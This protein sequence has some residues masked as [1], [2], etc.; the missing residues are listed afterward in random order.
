MIELFRHP[1]SRTFLWLW[2]GQTISTFGTSVSAFALGVYLYE[3]TGQATPLAILGIAR[4]LPQIVL[5]PLAGVLVDRIDRKWAMLLSDVGQG[6]AILAVLTLFAAGQ[7]QPWLI[8][9]LFALASLADSLRWT[10]EAATITLLVPTEHLGRANGL[11]SLGEGLGGIGGPAAAGVLLALIGISHLLAIDVLTYALDVVILLS[12]HIPRA[13]ITEA[14][15]QA[16]SSFRRELTI[17]WRYIR[18]RSGLL[19]LLLVTAAANLVDI[20]VAWRLVP[21]LILA[22]TSGNTVTLGLVG[23]TFDLGMLAGGIAM[24]VWGGPRP[25][26]LGVLGGSI[27]VAL[28][29]EVLFGLGHSLPIWLLAAFLGPFFIPIRLGS[30]HT[31]WQSTVEPDL[32]GKVFA[33]RRAISQITFP[34]GLLIVGPLA[35]DVATPAMHGALGHALRPLF[36][37]GPGRSYAIVMVIFGLLAALVYALGALLPSVRDVET[38]LHDAVVVAG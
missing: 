20:S 29:G 2:L 38:R 9:L 7:L 21:P 33:V 28:A 3:T 16:K 11:Q 15:R 32:Q 35:D 19:Q 30:S 5:S 36:G 13:Q 22:E 25:R 24:T 18:A 37:A 26:I 6:L 17:G 27:L 8:Y 1:G 12:L 14:G 23:S 31:I 34:L 4:F 10:A